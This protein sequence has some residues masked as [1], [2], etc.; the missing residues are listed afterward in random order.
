[1]HYPISARTGF[2]EHLPVIVLQAIVFVPYWLQLMHYQTDPLVSVSPDAIPSTKSTALA[3]A[4]SP[5]TTLLGAD[6]SFLQ[7]PHDLTNH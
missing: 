6:L 1:M 3:N 5:W 2:F 7:F 4:L